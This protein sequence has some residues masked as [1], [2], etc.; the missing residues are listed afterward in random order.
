VVEP[1]LRVERRYIRKDLPKCSVVTVARGI[2]RR[3]FDPML[4]CTRYRKRVIDN[5]R[6]HLDGRFN[7]FSFY[8][9]TPITSL[10]CATS[11]GA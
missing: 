4:H 2:G 9:A 5:S 3:K 7:L 10:T 1:R 8:Q 6:E 11:L